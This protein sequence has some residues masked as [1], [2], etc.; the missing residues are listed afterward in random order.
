M[1][2]RESGAVI[3]DRNHIAVRL[4]HAKS[5]ESI[6]ETGPRVRADNEVIDIALTSHGH[7]NAPSATTHKVRAGMRLKDTHDWVHAMLRV[8]WA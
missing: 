3:K 4:G 8:R 5:P 1:P 7:S 6:A 2:Y